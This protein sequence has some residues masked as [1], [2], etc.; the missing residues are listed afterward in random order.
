MPRLP[1]V[2][3]SRQHPH[4]HHVVYY[5]FAIR[6]AHGLIVALPAACLF[7]V[8]YGS[9]NVL[10]S[11]FTLLLLFSL[12]SVLT[13][14]V[15]GIY[16]DAIFSNLFRFRK[17]FFAWAA[18]F[19]LLLFV[20]KALQFTEFDNPLFLS[21]WFV[22]SLLGFGIVRLAQL[23]LFRHFSRQGCFLQHAV[24]LG[25]TESGIHAAK[26]ILHDGDVRVGMMGFIDDRQTR[27]P[28]QLSDFPFLGD[29]RKLHQLIREG[30][31]HQ[32]L[33]TLPWSAE[34][35]I[36]EIIQELKR[37]PV[38]VFLVPDS[39]ALNHAHGH[40]GDLAGLPVFNISQTPLN[41]WS[42]FFK[43]LEDVVLS[44]L[45]LTALLPLMLLIAA[46]IKLDSRGPV[47]F[48]Q[49]R[50]GYNN[51]LIEVF[52]FRTMFVHAS[53]SNGEQQTIRDDPRVTRIGRLLRKTSLDELPQLLN[54][55]LGSMSLVGP[56]PHATATK[57]G[58]V[59]FEEAVKEYS[60][61]HRVKPGITGW[62]QVNGYR[63]ETDTLEKIEKRVKYDLEYI[64]NWSVWFDLYIIFRT[65][66]AVFSTH[67]AY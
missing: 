63:G 54:V 62:A 14:Q 28:D 2:S 40:I 24:I 33:V 18:A 7:A 27:L 22:A 39:V 47:F 44:A 67:A 15:C 13:F 34:Q 49:Q 29:V 19:C 45:F 31:V 8:E 21:I 23:M 38:N 5:L 37:Y 35:R 41:G 42:P 30:K 32:V 56:R 66:P 50:Y 58:G 9:M 57:A 4:P 36:A 60:A 3:N 20:F 52:K 64:E 16:G 6:L 26:R 48:R 10:A 65:I 61:R 17:M 53:D 46:A 43:R 1:S 11:K 12:L 55:L 59:P 25:G 51:R